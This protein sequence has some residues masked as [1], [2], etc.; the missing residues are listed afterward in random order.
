MHHFREDATVPH[1]TPLLIRCINCLAIG[2]S[3]THSYLERQLSGINSTAQGRND[4][5]Y[6]GLDSKH[7]QLHLFNWVGIKPFEN[8]TCVCVFVYISCNVT[9]MFIFLKC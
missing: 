2:K 8:G 5:T 4:L 9:L 6:S 3:D 7:K 1:G